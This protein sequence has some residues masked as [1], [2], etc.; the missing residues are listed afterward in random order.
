MYRSPWSTIGQIGQALGQTL[1]QGTQIFGARQ[2][3]QG[4][5]IKA[6]VGQQVAQMEGYLADANY[7][8]NPD[9]RQAAEDFVTQG[10]TL[11]S[12]DDGAVPAS[13]AE[14]QQRGI[15]VRTPAG[16]Q[17]QAGMQTTLKPYEGGVAGFL[18]DIG[19][20]VTKATQNREQLEQDMDVARQL[21][22]SGNEQDFTLKRDGILQKYGMDMAQFENELGMAATQQGLDANASWQRASAFAGQLQGLTS[23]DDPKNAATAERIIANAK[24]AG[25]TAGDLAM[26][27]GEYDA[28]SSGTASLNWQ[29]RLKQSELSDQAVQL[30][31]QQITLNGQ[32]MELGEFM[33]SDQEYIANRRGIEDALSDRAAMD[34]VITAA[35]A[36]GDD[37]ELDHLMNVLKGGGAVS[38]EI[39]QALTGAGITLETLQENYGDAMNSDAF[40]ER[41]RELDMT[42]MRLA[43]DQLFRA[44]TLSEIELA[45]TVNAYGDQ[46]SKTMTPAEI[47]AAL[48]DPKSKLS[49][50]MGSGV[51]TQSDVTSMKRNAWTQQL[52]QR[53]ELAA[54]RIEQN[55]KMLET[56]AAVPADD[57][58]AENSL[59]ATLG[60]LVDDGMLTEE[61]VDGVVSSY[62][63]A[64]DYGRQT[65]NNELAASRAQLAYTQALTGAQVSAAMGSATET[66][67]SDDTQSQW[68]AMMES[69]A[70]DE[71]TIMNQGK[72]AGCFSEDGM[73]T[74]EQGECA[75]I[76]P[77]LRRVQGERQQAM[78]GFLDVLA[79]NEARLATED[80]SNR[81][82]TAVQNDP[83]FQGAS[84][85][86]VEHEALTR[87]ANKYGLGTAPPPLEPA[88]PPTAATP[89]QPRTLAGD[90]RGAANAVGGALGEQGL[91]GNLTEGARN[92]GRYVTGQST[93]TEQPPQKSREGVQ[94][95]ST[96]GEGT[97]ANL[98]Q[99]GDYTALASARSGISPTPLGAREQQAL[100][101]RLSTRYG[102]TAQALIAMIDR[103][104]S[105]SPSSPVAAPTVPMS[106][107]GGR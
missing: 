46:I 66:G 23:L 61:Q 64:W 52:V 48:S 83:A 75:N 55:F 26:V 1:L 86:E 85:A 50:F 103:D 47:D 57:T 2:A 84:E 71:D 91:M 3:Q 67:W 19:Q 31:S 15:N 12:M 9:E 38:P 59:R 94:I 49:M 42:E 37:K 17:G 69:Y 30:G 16:Q 34:E 20:G 54:P 100:I 107:D 76:V 98:H 39:Y 87:L 21:R 96:T 8:W 78:R 82:F 105:S 88:P 24:A 58:A 7:Q 80:I 60:A 33:L 28:L 74:S 51:L 95:T 32:Q 62:K 45:S 90:A 56:L 63:N 35:V 4:Q 77:E 102:I 101:R 72:A 11:L 44:D 99:D 68:D 14:W 79:P 93:P 29:D 10:K 27:Q 73:M 104:L 36:N 5:N 106:S 65:Q 81:V 18:G 40:L 41:K 43:E 6:Q 89:A 13:Y 53:Q 25:L 97:T 22:I 92:L 70:A